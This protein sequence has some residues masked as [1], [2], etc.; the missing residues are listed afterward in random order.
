LREAAEAHGGPLTITAYERAVRSSV[1]RRRS[2]PVPD[3]YSLRFGSWPEAIAA[4]GLPATGG[5]AR[6][7]RY[8]RED[9]LSAVTRLA[10]QIGKE[11]TI[12]EYDAWAKTSEGVPSSMTVVNRCGSWREAARGTGCTS[13]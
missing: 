12:R 11:P 10:A 1:S 6:Q 9:C 7:R 3:T 13:P 5:R 2:W 8:S 4:A